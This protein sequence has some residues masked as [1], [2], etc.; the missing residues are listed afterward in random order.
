MKCQTTSLIH[1]ITH[2]NFFAFSLLR[3]F[4]HHHH[5]QRIL[6]FIWK[7]EFTIEIRTTRRRENEKEKVIKVKQISN[8]KMEKI[9]C[10]HALCWIGTIDRACV[11]ACVVFF[12]PFYGMN[13]TPNIS[14]FVS[15]FCDLFFSF[16]VVHFSA[17]LISS[18][19][20]CCCCCW[21]CSQPPIHWSN[22]MGDEVPLYN[23]FGIE[24][25][26]CVFCKQSDDNVL[27]LGDKFTYENITIHLFCAV[28]I[29]LCILF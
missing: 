3:F 24:D 23:S 14:Q 8:T 6:F 18:A 27:E 4:Y 9:F 22:K 17:V 16:L 11:R 13:P 15:F 28:H 10:F 12:V 20:F 1:T 2:S 29:L 25:E 26:K 19:D 5:C 21:V 7:F